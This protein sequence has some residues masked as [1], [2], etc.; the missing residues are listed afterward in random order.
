MYSRAVGGVIDFQLT[1]RNPQ[2]TFAMRSENAK[3]VLLL[4]LICG[5]VCA[6]ATSVRGTPVYPEEAI[7]ECIE[8][9]VVLEYTLAESGRAD[10][11]VVIDADPPGVFEA[12]AI[13][14][15]RSSKFEP[16]RVDGVVFA[17]RQQ[18]MT[19]RFELVEAYL[20]CHSTNFDD[21]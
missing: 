11:I 17:V 8:G 19:L 4:V 18:Q 9:Y 20:H 12:A 21:Q 16:R 7:Q 3:S 15:L 6:S 5:S 1:G 2:E 13:K 10:D 14:A